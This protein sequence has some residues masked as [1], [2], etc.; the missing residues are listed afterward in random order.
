LHLKFSCCTFLWAFSVFILYLNLFLF[1]SFFSSICSRCVVFIFQLTYSRWIQIF[2]CSIQEFWLHSNFHINLFMFHSILLCIKSTHAVVRLQ[3]IFIFL[4]LHA[5]STSPLQSLYA[6]FNV[7][8]LNSFLHVKNFYLFSYNLF[9]LLLLNSTFSHIYIYIFDA[10]LT[11]PLS[12][13]M[14][15]IIF[16][17]WIG[18]I[19]VAFNIVCFIQIFFYCSQSIHLTLRFSILINMWCFSHKT[20]FTFIQRIHVSFSLF[21]LI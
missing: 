7:F 15:C 5:I 1:R 20:F 2:Q 9:H 14:F 17:R 19:K 18:T 6:F 21:Q 8:M 4:L 12:R 3:I 16:S 10:T 11:F 13:S